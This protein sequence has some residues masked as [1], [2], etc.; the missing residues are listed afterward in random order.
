MQGTVSRKEWL[1]QGRI[2]VGDGF[3]G[4]G[5]ENVGGRVGDARFVALIESWGGKERAASAASAWVH[6]GAL[7][8]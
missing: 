6:Q 3:V 8:C 4:G 5:R 7:R 2:H 1:M